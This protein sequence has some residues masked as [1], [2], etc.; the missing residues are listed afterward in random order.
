MFFIIILMLAFPFA[1]DGYS[2]FGSNCSVENFMSCLALRKSY[3][4]KGT[5][6]NAILNGI[7]IVLIGFCMYRSR[8]EKIQTHS[9]HAKTER[10]LIYQAIFSSIFQLVYFSFKYASAVSDGPWFLIF[11]YVSN[12]GYHI[13]HYVVMLTH[14]ILSPTFKAAYLNFYHLGKF[15]KPSRTFPTTTISKG[16]TIKVSPVSRIAHR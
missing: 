12:I 9:T 16:A 14:F 2:L 5:I 3:Y 11:M 15:I 7:I 4:L 6:I 1:A 8:K 10:R 13:H